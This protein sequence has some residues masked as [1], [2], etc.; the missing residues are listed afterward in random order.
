MTDNGQ[1]SGVDGPAAVRRQLLRRMGV[2][3]V[4]ILALLAALAIF[5][6]V[7]VLDED[8]LSRPQFSEPVPVGRREVVQA[9][10]PAEAVP[11]PQAVAET[12]PEPPEEIS[13]ARSGP[14]TRV[15]APSSPMVPPPQPVSPAKNSF[16][17]IAPIDQAPPPVEPAAAAPRWSGRYAWQSSTFMD[18]RRAEDL[19]TRLAEEGIPATLEARLQV[20]PFASRSE[21]E[22]A[23]RTML[24]L[25]ISVSPVRNKKDKP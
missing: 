6:Y 5:D 1:T 23:R 21:A 16:A 2:A 15:A 4:L 18:L 11:E 10:K 3:A 12:P 9:L 19:Q 14:D 17:R 20:G 8:G 13:P 7:N 25:G 24:G 22:A